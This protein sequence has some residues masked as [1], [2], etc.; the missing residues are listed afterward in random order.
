MKNKLE[1]ERGDIIISG[2]H[3]KMGEF[4]CRERGDHCE[5]IAMRYVSG[6]IVRVPC[7]MIRRATDAEAAEFKRRKSPGS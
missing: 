3:P 6:T 5:M 7:T 2:L 4:I 1:F